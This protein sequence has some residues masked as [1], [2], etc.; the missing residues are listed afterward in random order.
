MTRPISLALIASVFAL[1]AGA[2][3]SSSSPTTAGSA[4][5]TALTQAA[6]IGASNRVTADNQTIQQPQSVS[7]LT[8]LNG[9]FGATGLNLITDLFD[10]QTLLT[11]V[12][13]QIC[14]AIRQTWSSYTSGAG[15]GIALTGFNLGIGGLGGGVS[16]PRLTF[17]GGGPPLASFGAGLG[18]G[19]GTGLYINGNG[20]P[21][22][23]YAL[24][25]TPQGSF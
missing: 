15:C 23:G 1:P 7:S 25:T 4:G 17:G 5:C 8:C 13:N 16:C 19:G 18:G 2:Q 3:T 20:Q 6:A 12:Q 21:P 10:P 11:Q 22:T 24:P 14:Q 9:I